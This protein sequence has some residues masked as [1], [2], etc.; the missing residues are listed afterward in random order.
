M[1]DETKKIVSFPLNDTQGTI[2][3]HGYGIVNEFPVHFH[4]TF[5]V[6]IVEKGKRMFIYRGQE[7]VIE[8]GDIFIIHPFEPHVCSSIDGAPHTYKIISLVWK[9]SE[10]VPYFDRLSYKAPEI[11]ARLSK[12]HTLAE[13]KQAGSETESLLDLLL[14]KLSRLSINVETQGTINRQ[15]ELTE[16]A[17][18]FIEENCF[19]DI[20]LG[21]IASHVNLSEYHFNRMFHQATGMSPYGYLLYRKIRRSA[22]VLLSENNVTTATY[23]AGFYDQSHFIRLFKK[24]IGVTPGNYLRANKAD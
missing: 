9:Q 14:E 18:Q 4:T 6:G 21:D 10:R 22:D 16:K 2:V 24:H 20:S 23:S 17:R 15:D 5:T 12:F 7:T 3:T 11:A 8:A 1:K 13:Y 19:N